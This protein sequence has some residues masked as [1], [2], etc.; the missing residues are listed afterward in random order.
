MTPITTGSRAS[1]L[2]ELKGIPEEITVVRFD[3]FERLSSPFELKLTLASTALIALDDAMS[4]EAL[5]TIRADGE[6]RFVH[7]IVNRFEFVGQ[8]GSSVQNIKYLYRARVVPFT[9]LLSL[10]RD[11]RIFQNKNVQDIVEDIFKDSGIPSDRYE[12]KLKIKDHKRRFC[13]QYRESDLDF[14]TRILYE[15]G[16]FYFYTHT[17]DKHVMIFGDDAG[18]SPDIPGE[19]EIAFR[20]ASGLNPEKDVISVIEFSKR[21]RPGA[22]TQTNYN[23]K[24]VSIPLETKERSKDEKIRSFE[25]YDYPG[26]YGDSD[27]GKMLAK[28]RLEELTALQEQASGESNCPRLI[29]GHVFSLT[30][31]D[32]KEF[33]RDY[34]VV[35]LNVSGS[36]PQSMEEQ[37]GIGGTTFVSEFVAIPASVTYRPRK[38]VEKPYIQGI[39]TATVVG[40]ANEEIYV[41]E[42]GR[43]KV[44]F[45]WDRKGKKDEQ[46]SCWLRC[47]QTWGGQGWGSVFIPR[48]GDEVIVSFM[49]GDPDWPIITGSV[50]NA[51]RPPLYDLPANKTR[52]S[53][54]TKSY[55]NSNGFNELRFEDLAGS[56][57]IYLQGEKDWNILIKNNKGENV[58]HDETLSVVNNRA[59][60]VG[61]NQSESIGANKNI[62]VGGSH[63]ESIGGSMML[64]VGANKTD[65]TAAVSAET[66]G[67][68]KVLTVGG[69]Y[70]VSVGGAANLTI[71]GA[72]GEEVGGVKT[73]MVGGS[74]MESV[75]GD[76]T[77][78]AGG[79]HTMKAKKIAIEAED[80]VSIKAGGATIVLKKSGDITINGKDI[81]V[82][83]SG[84]VVVKGSKVAHN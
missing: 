77:A 37:A 35:Q 2:F 9:E 55:P 28:V 67:A 64:T 81:S 5:F 51:D 14:I 6:D 44:H 72:S 84:D 59:K 18:I 22:Y 53:I 47:A 65:T 12:F 80:E 61:V 63:S 3:L 39:Q 17:P 36:Q 69:A 82:K 50:Y 45:H 20:A 57:E 27:R 15:E 41:D 34:L 52:T 10:E 26:P 68:A 33:N 62:L 8:T 78:T 19:K 42:H 71:G 13:V 31:Y 54:K 7:G 70:Q 11:C 83:A 24:K 58:G 76:R 48:I 4:Q 40:P 74:M 56:E 66:V 32:F 73:L 75:G 60:T 30:D 23:F 21:L 1:Y 79:T 43:V 29:P 16:I 25:V 46:S 38:T 49:E